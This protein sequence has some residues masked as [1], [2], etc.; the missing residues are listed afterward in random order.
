VET[1]D[2][3]ADRAVA[4]VLS[5]PAEHQDFA[6]RNPRHPYILRWDVA[7]VEAL[8]RTFPQ[9]WKPDFTRN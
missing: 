9:W 6:L 2:R 1:A 7:R 3:D 5:G 4:R 8:Q